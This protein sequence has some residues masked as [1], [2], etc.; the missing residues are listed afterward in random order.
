M[1]RTN[2]QSVS[3]LISEF[4]ANNPKLR[5]KL[6]ENRIVQAW[7]QVLGPSIMDYTQDIYVKNRILYVSLQSSVW[8]N[9]L[10]MRRK[11]LVENLNERAGAEVITDIVFR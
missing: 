8:R 11:K 6:L 3:E 2:T 9:E 10:F 5:Q 4:L 1:K 7:S